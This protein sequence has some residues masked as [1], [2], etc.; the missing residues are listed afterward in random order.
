MFEARSV[1]ESYC[2]ERKGVEKIYTKLPQ[3]KQNMTNK[4]L[5]LHKAISVLDLN[6]VIEAFGEQLVPL[7]SK[8]DDSR[9]R[10]P[11]KSPATLT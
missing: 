4:Q 5:A 8:G 3:Q 10:V 11:I 1:E 6:L 2:F 9:G 7:E